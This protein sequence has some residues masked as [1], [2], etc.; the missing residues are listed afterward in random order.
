MPLYLYYY[1]LYCRHNQ[2]IADKKP[3]IDY[4]EDLIQRSEM[5]ENWIFVYECL[6]VFF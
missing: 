3:L 4:A 5:E 1:I 6:L 2:L